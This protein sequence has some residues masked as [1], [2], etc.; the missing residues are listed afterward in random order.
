MKRLVVV[1]SDEMDQ[2]ML[3]ILFND[4]QE[5]SAELVISFDDGCKIVVDVPDE[6]PDPQYLATLENYWFN[7]IEE[8]MHPCCI[9]KMGYGIHVHAVFSLQRFL[10]R[11]Q[12]RNP[13]IPGGVYGEELNHLV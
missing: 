6:I 3:D 13:N 1:F 10:K 5:T 12:E 7:V 8:S 11:D 4:L 2:E 9:S